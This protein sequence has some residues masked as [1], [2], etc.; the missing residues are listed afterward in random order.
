MSIMSLS[1]ELVDLKEPEMMS[2]KTSVPATD[3][4]RWKSENSPEKPGLE[5]ACGFIHKSPRPRLRYEIC[6]FCEALF[7]VDVT[8]I[9]PKIASPVFSNLRHSRQINNQR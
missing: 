1:S 8:D 2:K 9:R 5:F 3:Q 7:Y 6:W 4:D